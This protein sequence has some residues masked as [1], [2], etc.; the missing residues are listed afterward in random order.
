M[1]NSATHRERRRLRA[2][3]KARASRAGHTPYMGIRLRVPIPDDNFRRAVEKM[4]N[5]QR[6]IWCRMGCPGKTGRS[7]ATLQQF[8]DARSLPKGI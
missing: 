5:K 8:A 4:T 1:S 3:D 7:L 2:R 6:Q